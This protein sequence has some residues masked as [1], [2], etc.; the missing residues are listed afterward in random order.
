M[1]IDFR[2]CLL[3]DAFIYSHETEYTNINS[4]RVN[5][6]RSKLLTHILFW[7][8]YQVLYLTNLLRCI[9]PFVSIRLTDRQ[10]NSPL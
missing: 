2:F 3:L 7:C 4:L 10:K 1:E 9:H 5:S 8:E 6:F